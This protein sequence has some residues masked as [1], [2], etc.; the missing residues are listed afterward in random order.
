VVPHAVLVLLHLVLSLL[1]SL[2]WWWRC[3]CTYYY[4]S[5]GIRCARPPV[6]PWLWLASPPGTST[7]ATLLLVPGVLVTTTTMMITFNYSLR[8]GGRAGHTHEMR[9]R[10]LSILSRQMR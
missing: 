4:C 5:A 10:Q 1:P 6:R 7:S 3:C 8:R 9:G 2:Y